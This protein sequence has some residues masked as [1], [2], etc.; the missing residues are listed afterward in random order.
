M[1]LA[2]DEVSESLDLNRGGRRP[3]SEATHGVS[4]AADMVVT[5]SRIWRT[6]M[7]CSSSSAWTDG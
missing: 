6:S 5:R 2:P 7:N 4:D 3:R 1:R